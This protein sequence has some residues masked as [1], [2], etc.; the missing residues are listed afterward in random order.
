MSDWQKV[1][2]KYSRQQQEM[3]NEKPVDPAY[4]DLAEILLALDNR[5]WIKDQIKMHTDNRMAMQDSLS[6]LVKQ[7]QAL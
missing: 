4:D 6:N 3:I 1:L 7:R 2:S 5:N